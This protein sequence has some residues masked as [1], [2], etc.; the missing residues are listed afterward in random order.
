MF[1]EESRGVDLMVSFLGG[2]SLLLVVFLWVDL[3]LLLEGR[4]GL[5]LGEWSCVD[6]IFFEV[7]S[8][9]G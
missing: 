8:L 3:D 1:S 2:L 6:L 9:M 7:M 5:S 4:V